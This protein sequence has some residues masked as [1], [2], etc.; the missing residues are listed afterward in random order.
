MEY[1][2]YKDFNIKEYFTSILS[3]WSDDKINYF[4]EIALKYFKEPA[5]QFL[6][7]FNIDSIELDSIDDVQKK[8]QSMLYRNLD[9]FIIIKE[10]HERSVTK[11]NYLDLTDKGWA[12]LFDFTSHMLHLLASNDPNPIF[13]IRKNKRD[14]NYNTIQLVL[15]KNTVIYR[16]FMNILFRIAIYENLEPTALSDELSMKSNKGEFIT[17]L[18]AS[19][20]KRWEEIVK[21]EKTE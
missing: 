8:M 21:N 10:M 2:V 3:N 5:P 12:L 19:L 18:R 7:F 1:Q 15:E 4:Y 20:D 13:N 14:I 9:F 6:S 17:N 16:A 11:H